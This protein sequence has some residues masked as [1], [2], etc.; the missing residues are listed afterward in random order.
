ME[1]TVAAEQ[2]HEVPPSREGFVARRRRSFMEKSRRERGVVLVWF[3]LMLVVLMGFAGLAVDL[4]NWWLQAER[5][6]RAA[7]SGAPAGVVNVL[8]SRRS[9]DVTRAMLA[10]PQRSAALGASEGLGPWL[11]H[12]RR[13]DLER[14]LWAAAW[15]ERDELA[16]R[17]HQLVELPLAEPSERASARR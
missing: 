16:P 10:D 13:S 11:L 8:T 15:L 17:T 1:P 4:S 6:Q 2:D 3:A 14:T 7:A 5:L 12:G 9:G